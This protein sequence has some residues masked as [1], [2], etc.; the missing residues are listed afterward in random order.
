MVRR[1]SCLVAVSVFVLSGALGISGPASAQGPSNWTRITTPSKTFTY[2]V[3]STGGA[4]NQ[5]RVSGQAG[6]TSF[7]SVNIVCVVDTPSGGFG[8]P[9]LATDV[10]VTNGSFTVLAEVPQAIGICRLRAIPSNIPDFGYLG[11][12]SGPIM[13]SYSFGKVED[14]SATVSFAVATAFGSGIAA[15][16]D[17]AAC[18]VAGMLTIDMPDVELRG[19]GTPMCALGLHPQNITASGTPTASAVRVDGKNAYL[20]GGVSGFLRDPAF[21]GL[22]LSQPSITTSF[23][24]NGN[25][26]DVTVTESLRL[27]RCNGDNTIPPTAQTC[28]SLVGTGITFKQVLQLIRGNHQ[29]LIH[30][31]FVSTDGHAHTV[32]AQYQSQISRARDGEPGYVYPKHASSFRRAALDQVVTGLGAG[33]ASVLVRSDFYASSTDVQADTQ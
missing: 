28:S 33:P 2:H 6:G 10:P 20:P 14:A 8:G 3:D 31:S 23:T 30:D 21:L 26:G 25:T 9:P 1:I 11:A 5:L 32:T 12:F 4:V 27:M 29:V 19:P 22:T 17:A 15:L 16:S 7:T 24:R 18:P 13:Y